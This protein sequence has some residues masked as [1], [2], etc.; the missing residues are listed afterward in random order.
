M[1]KNGDR[2][3]VMKQKENA[4]QRNEITV[5][6]KRQ[7]PRRVIKSTRIQAKWL[8]V[9]RRARRR[10]RHRS[11]KGRPSSSEHRR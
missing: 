10:R 8:I 6:E 3:A 1:R 7:M 2:I 4:N 9:R 11:G 5:Q